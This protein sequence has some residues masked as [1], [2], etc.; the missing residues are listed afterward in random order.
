MI[1]LSLVVLLVTAAGAEKEKPWFDMENCAMCKSFMG[2]A[3]LM[4][5]LTWEHHDISNGIL[6]VTVVNEKYLDA[7]R[8]AHAEMDKTAMRLQKGEMLD[9]CGSCAVIGM[10]MMKGA[11][12]EYVETSTGDVWILTSDKPEVVA[13]LQSWAKRSKEETYKLKATKG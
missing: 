13:E 6:S 9:M 2:T 11:K 4:D 1:T 3:G 7:Y 12:Q 10:C 8:A 5:N